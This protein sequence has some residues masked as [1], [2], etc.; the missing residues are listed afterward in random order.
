MVAHAMSLPG[1]SFR[2][3][4]VCPWARHHIGRLGLQGQT[5]ALLFR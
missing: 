3:G 5:L 4:R 2:P 1:I